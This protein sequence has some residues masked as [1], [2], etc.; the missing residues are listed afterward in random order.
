VC[1]DD[2][3]GYHGTDGPLVVSDVIVTSLAEAFVVAGAEHGHEFTDV[4]AH[5]Q[6]GLL[7]CLVHSQSFMFIMVFRV[8]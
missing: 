3:A 4:N 8:S 2:T 1:I 5:S 7:Q 6:H